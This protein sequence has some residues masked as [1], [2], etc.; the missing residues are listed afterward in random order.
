[1]SFRLFTY[2]SLKVKNWNSRLPIPQYYGFHCRILWVPNTLYF[3]FNQIS[4]VTPV[5]VGDFLFNP[6]LTILSLGRGFTIVFWLTLFAIPTY[7]FSADVWPV[8]RPPAPVPTNTT[9][10][11]SK[12]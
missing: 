1:M 3:Q 11:G 7:F 4:A 9:A 2:L 8:I 5:D 12:L 10:A 6:Q